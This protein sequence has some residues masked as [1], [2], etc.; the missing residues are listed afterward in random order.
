MKQT[1][2]SFQKLTLSL[3]RM[4]THSRRIPDRTAE[5]V[6][7]LKAHEQ[8]RETSHAMLL[9]ELKTLEE[10]FDKL[11]SQTK[12]DA[13]NNGQTVKAF[14]EA[15][16]LDGQSLA[17][18]FNGIQDDLGALATN[19]SQN[20]NAE[21][22]ELQHLDEID[23]QSDHQ[24]IENLALYTQALQVS[25]NISGHTSDR[26]KLGQRTLAVDLETEEQMVERANYRLAMELNLAAARHMAEGRPSGAVQELKQATTLAPENVEILL[27]LIRALVEVFELQAAQET[28]TMVKSLAT[29]SPRVFQAGAWLAMGLGNFVEATTLFRQAITPDL[30]LMEELDVME[31]LASA[32]FQAG[33]PDLAQ[34]AWERVLEIDPFHPTARLSMDRTRQS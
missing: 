33:R 18:N 4:R 31:G 6:K 12:Q 25:S 24:R 14:G 13:E 17:T 9:S 21:S 29:P 11:T 10:N 3:D 1:I 22:R 34:K 32:E 15:I 27:N 16:Q 2:I 19:L 23:V 20:I 30:S 5:A 8:Q 26:L 28:Y 7:H